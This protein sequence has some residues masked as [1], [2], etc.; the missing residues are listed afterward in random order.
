LKEAFIF[1]PTNV[2]CLSVNF[3]KLD[4]KWE[5]CGLPDNVHVFVREWISY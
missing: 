1:R 5:A 4:R 2:C 3:L